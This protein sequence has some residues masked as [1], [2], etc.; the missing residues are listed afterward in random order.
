MPIGDSDLEVFVQDFGVPVVFGG[1][2]KTGIFNKP[3]KSALADEGFGGIAMSRPSVRLPFNAFTPMPEPRNAITVNG[4]NYTIA[5]EEAETD[6]AFV[7]YP[8]KAAS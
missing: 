3:T 5:D 6:G 2:T 8:L 4:S 7:C 1:V